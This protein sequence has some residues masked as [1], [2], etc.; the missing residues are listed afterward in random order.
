MLRAD[1]GI[2]NMALEQ[3]LEGAG[4]NFLVPDLPAPVPARVRN[5]AFLMR[6]F[7]GMPADVD[8]HGNWHY[9]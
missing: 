6:Q 5:A 4:Q 9:N 1:A 2:A 7:C 3:V 8:K